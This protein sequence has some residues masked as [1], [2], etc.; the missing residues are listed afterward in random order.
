MQ[1]DLRFTVT[2]DGDVKPLQWRF[3]CMGNRV[4]ACVWQLVN[5][6]YAVGA[7]LARVF[8]GARQRRQ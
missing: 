4:E 8:R 7:N 2:H 3:G 1:Q 5:V 6:V